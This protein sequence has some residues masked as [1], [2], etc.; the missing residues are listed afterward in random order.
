MYKTIEFTWV[1]NVQCT[2]TLVVRSCPTLSSSPP[3]SIALH[4]TS[5]FSPCHSTLMQFFFYL[6]SLPP[7]FTLSFPFFIPCLISGILYW[8]LLASQIAIAFGTLHHISTNLDYKG[9]NSLVIPPSKVSQLQ[10]TLPICLS[11]Y[12]THFSSNA[13][14]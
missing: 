8:R 1:H 4:F 10:V 9:C 12:Y 7:N 6:N 5:L 2:C 13:V 3:P 11:Q 14:C